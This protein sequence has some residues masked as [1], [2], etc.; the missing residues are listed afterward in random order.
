MKHQIRFIQARLGDSGWGNLRG[1]VKCDSGGGDGV[2][3]GLR[4][5]GWGG[6]GRQRTRMEV[7]RI[8][9]LFWGGGYL[10]LASDFIHAALKGHKFYSLYNRH[11]KSTERRRGTKEQ[12]KC[13]NINE[14]W[15]F[16]FFFF[17]V[18]WIGLSNTSKLSVTG[19]NCAVSFILR[20]SLY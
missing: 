12:E 17:K 13:G 10:H 20:H 15:C 1:Q 7:R 18:N 2:L 3:T 14:P 5:A 9:F 6:G 4:S 19:S 16:F 8:F 11:H